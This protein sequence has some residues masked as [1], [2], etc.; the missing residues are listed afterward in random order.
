M[1][2]FSFTCAKTCL[3]ILASESWPS[4]YCDVVVLDK[5]GVVCRGKY[6][7]YG[8]VQIDS[9]EEMEVFEDVMADRVR[10]V[11][12][13]FYERETFAELRRCVSDPG[14]G[15]FYDLESIE[16]WWAKGGFAS[17]KELATAYSNPTT[18]KAREARPLL[19]LLD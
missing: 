1:G 18:Q 12:A 15:H 7:G 8:R 16:A 6:D 13:S 9:G 14:Q 19:F 17:P 11:L 5:D 10:L 2:F 3:P 4:P